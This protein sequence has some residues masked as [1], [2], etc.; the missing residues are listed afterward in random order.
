MQR[1]PREARKGN[2]HAVH[3]QVYHLLDPDELE[4][5]RKKQP[6]VSTVIG[7][8]SHYH[9]IFI[10][11]GKLQMRWLA[12]PCVSCLDK[13]WI[14]CVNKHFIGEFQDVTMSQFNHVGR[15]PRLQRRKDKWNAMADELSNG[16]IIATYCN[17]DLRGHKYWLAKVV[18]LAG[19]SDVAPTLKHD[20]ECEI[21]GEEF[22]NGER[23]VR[24]N[25]YDRVG[26]CSNQFVLCE[27]LGVFTIGAAV[28]RLVGIQLTQVNTIQTRRNT[29]QIYEI[30]ER[31]HKQVLFNIEHEFGDC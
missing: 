4:A 15:G 23:V 1:S 26:G 25:Y 3:Q 8:Q 10:S 21:T 2:S 13:Q 18:M 12:C 9:Y 19:Q 22:A 17:E 29:S 7:T 30:S 11:E 27:D 6:E 14:H 20:E 31:D 24:V 5:A 28:L 16:D